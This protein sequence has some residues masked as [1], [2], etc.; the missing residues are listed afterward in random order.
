MPEGPECRTDALFLNEHLAGQQ[1]LSI[2]LGD[3]HGRLDRYLEL[4]S[5]LISATI[6]QV[7]VYG[8]KIFFRFLL[9]NQSLLY[10]VVSYRMEGRFRLNEIPRYTWLVF[11]FADFFLSYSDHRYMGEF[12]ICLEE[13]VQRI[14]STLGPDILVMDLSW[15]YYNHLLVRKANVGICYFLLDQANVAGI[16]NYLKCDI[17]YACGINPHKKMSQLTPE[18]VLCLY[19][20]MHEISR[21][22]FADGACTLGTYKQING[23]HGGYSRL[24]YGREVDI[25]GQYRVIRE[26]IGG[27]G[28]YWCPE[29]QV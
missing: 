18:Q 23:R 20:A 9:P 11:R 29:I 27:R 8:K 15:E 6:L 2:E 21:R 7:G 14:L 24:V 22:A 26:T 5:S 12:Q 1:I 25:T 10:A 28:T 19:Q 16:G 17:L 4:L 13:E 3:H